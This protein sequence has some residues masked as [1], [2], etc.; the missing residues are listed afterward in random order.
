MD[1]A[2]W[3][4][5]GA[6]VLAIVYGLFSAKWILAQS[7]GSER[8]QEIAG[9]IQEGAG[10]YMNRQYGTIAIVGVLLFIVVGFALPDNGWLTAIGFA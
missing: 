8:M 1:A 9:A 7:A 5:L 2:L 4:S 10:A 6:A 3:L